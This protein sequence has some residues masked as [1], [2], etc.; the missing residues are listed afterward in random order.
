MNRRGFSLIEMMVAL[1]ILTVGVL[2]LA[3][4]A[5]VVTQMTGSGGRYGGASSVAASR[6]EQLRAATCTT[7]S[8]GSATTGR[9]TER[10]TVTTSG[11]LRVVD[12][13][14]TYNDGTSSRT[15]TYSTAISCVPEAT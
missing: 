12:L 6:F 15:A 10:W 4:S 8:A 2:G 3:A 11:Q 9:Y 1:V 13:A 7:L 5:R 14:I